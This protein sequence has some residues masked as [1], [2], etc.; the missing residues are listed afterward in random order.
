MFFASRRPRMIMAKEQAFLKAQEQF[1]NL[2]NRVELAARDGHRIDT[3]ERDLMRQLLGLGHTLLTA[4]VA[5][6]GDGDQGP[7]IEPEEGP[8]L[9]RLPT[10]HDRRYLSIF[11]ELTI[12]RV[13]YG[14]RE[15]QKIQRV[16]LDERL[17]LP[18]NS[19]SYVLENWSQRLCLKESFAEASNSLEMLL[20][21]RLGSRT[22]EQ[23]NQT[24]GAYA[25]PF[26][27]TIETPSADE[28]GPLL[29]VTA[30]GKGVPMRRPAAPG[31][32]PHHRRTKGEKANKKQM[33]C[34]GAV[35]SIEP[36]VRKPQNIRDEVLRH[37]KAE[38]RPRP[39]HKHVWAETSR[40]VDAFAVTAKVD[41]VF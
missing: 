22:L 14:T 4:F 1:D 7:S 39:Q 38:H 13:V 30:D 25:T 41:C 26:R 31:P 33:A 34:V 11:G 2:K 36:F 3:I 24:L 16:P 27:A 35:Y 20:G 5:Q 29:V 40:D 8:T 19:F 21:L 6:Q 17:G 23:L 10:N 12:S 28:E 32:K 9:Q 15:G 37:Q 18:E